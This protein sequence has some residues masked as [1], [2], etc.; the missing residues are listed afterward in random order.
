RA[1]RRHAG[2]A[3]AAPRNR[4]DIVA[5]LVGLAERF[6][7]APDLHLDVVLLD[8]QA[9]PDAVHQRVLGDELARRCNEDAQ[10]LEPTAA[11]RDQAV[12]AVER[13]AAQIEP[14]RTERD[15]VLRP[16]RDRLDAVQV[17][18]FLR[19]MF[20]ATRRAAGRR[21]RSRTGSARSGPD[22]SAP[23]R[24]WVGA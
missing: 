8:H 11:G 12:A 4:D 17:P 23:A 20:P 1:G 22:A 15:R 2:E 5:P 18:H 7:Q 10:H 14:E 6:A 9:G 19:F 21:R 24:T 16:W 3:I 13:L